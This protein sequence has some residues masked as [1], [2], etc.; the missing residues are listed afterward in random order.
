M[1]EKYSRYRI[2]Q[3]FFD[4]PRKQFHVRELSRKIKLAQSSVN[5][6]LKELLKEGFIIKVREGIYPSFKANRDSEEFKIYK[7]FDINLKIRQSG[8]LDFV[9]DSCLPSVIILFGSASKGEDIEDSDID[10]FI[11]CK[12][13][14]LNLEKYE[15]ALNRKI[16]LFFEENFSRLAKELKNNILNG[17]ILKGYIQV[18]D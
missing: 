13:K 16:N 7:K 6:H 2:L 14:K 18:F 9:Y 15:K 8:L 5:L 3:E 12:E 4:F 10:L 11:Q 1:I 17:I